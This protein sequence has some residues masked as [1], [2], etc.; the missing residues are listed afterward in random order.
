MKKADDNFTQNDKDKA[1]VLNAFFPS[2]FT[3]GD[4][5]P[6]PDLEKPLASIPM[7]ELTYLRINLVGNWR[8]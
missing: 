6:I 4:T 5:T 1:E 3:K 2:V 8:S 7:Q